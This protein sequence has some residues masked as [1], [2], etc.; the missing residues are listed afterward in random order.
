MTSS[1]PSRRAACLVAA[2]LLLASPAGVAQE[3]ESGQAPV[4]PPKSL[5]PAGKF[6]PA[7]AEP[8]PEVAPA[9]P[10]AGAAPGGP[11][12]L[13]PGETLPGGTPPGEASS[14]SPALRL[15]VPAADPTAG[16]GWLTLQTGG[17]APTL[18]SGSSGP[19]VNTV[20]R[21]MPAPTASRWAHISLRK[22]LLT[23]APT[24]AG[25]VPGN[26]IAERAHLLLRMGEVEGAKALVDRA[27]LTG[28]TKRLFEVAPQ[29]H[30]AAGDVAS[31]CPLT[32]TGISISGDPL[33][34]LMSAVCAALQGDDAGAALILDRER[35]NRSAQPFEIRLADRVAAAISGSNRAVSVNWPEAARLTTFRLGM[36]SVSGVDVPRQRLENANPAV[37]G[38]VVRNP[39]LPLATR[40][41]A[42]RTA[43]VTGALSSREMVNLLSLQAVSL[44]PTAL[45]ALPVG[46]LRQAYAAP[47]HE[48]RITALRNLWAEGKTRE[49]R[50]AYQLASA[51][52]AAQVPVKAAYLD[53]APALAR[54]MLLAGDVDGALAWYKL[55]RAEAK[56]GNAR[57]GRPLMALWPLVAT[58]EAHGRVPRSG[59]LFALWAKN[60]LDG[61]SDVV[62][63]QQQLAGAALLGLGLLD[64]TD[65][66]S[67]AVPEAIDNAFTRQLQA[68]IARRRKGEA[69]V[70]ASLGLGRDAATVK[71]AYVRQALQALCAVGLRREAGLIA[72]ELLIRNGV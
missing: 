67:A 12:T 64:H 39:N 31:L 34:P 68:V 24:P 35:E 49:D 46:E 25:V 63:R 6:A 4:A 33:W 45:A 72:A 62:D 27:P 3:S 55:A 51:H 48:A 42:A 54:A 65:L 14:R 7:P 66:P 16:V 28:Y 43:V 44:D 9:T 20:L 57:A 71:P 38:W 32:Q 61:D 30:L 50:L 5:L 29:A 60:W 1:R 23:Q 18:W 17:Y 13:L 19:F 53:A 15:Q 2:T 40:L 22:A 47:T 59:A 56:G 58:A 26:F 70:L 41:H 52:A 8:A 69:I 10:D 36:A 11:E 21:R 37:K